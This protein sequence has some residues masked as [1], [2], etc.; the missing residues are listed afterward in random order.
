MASAARK[1]QLGPRNFARFDDGAHL[2]LPLSE[3]RAPRLD[4]E[5]DYTPDVTGRE[6]VK[7]HEIDRASEKPRVFRIEPEFREIRDQLLVYFA[8]SNR[9]A[10][11]DGVFAD[12]G[13]VTKLPNHEVQPRHDDPDHDAKH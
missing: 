12:R 5:K 4:L 7:D 9:E 1:P 10:A 11:L 2:P 13:G 8:R 3:G 6:T